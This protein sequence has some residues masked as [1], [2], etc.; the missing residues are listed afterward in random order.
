MEVT[1]CIESELACAAVPSHRGGTPLFGGS[2]HQK[3]KAI[4]LTLGRVRLVAWVATCL[5]LALPAAAGESDP[6]RSRQWNL[7]LVGS[8]QAHA[9]STG[10]GA[11]VAVIDSGVLATHPDLA[12]RLLPAMSF[13]EDG[14]TRD[15]NGHGTH[16]AG[17]VAAGAGNGVGISSIAPGATVLPIRVLDAN[18]GG[19][20]G[21]IARGIDYAIEQRADVINLSLGEEVPLAAVGARPAPEIDNAIRR[22]LDAGIVVV[23]AAGNNALPLCDQPLAERG[24]LCVGAVDK[25]AMRGSY[26]SFGS[27]VGVMAPGGSG[28]PVEG[29]NVLST[30]GDGGYEEVAGTSPATAHV[31]AVAA[32]LVSLG[33]RGEEAARRIVATARDAGGAGVDPV[34]G[35]GILDARA[36]VSGLARPGVRGRASVRRNQRIRTV[37]RRGITVRCRPALSGRCSVKARARHRTI[38]R[39]SAFATAG[40]WTIVRARVTRA[41][42]RILRRIRRLDVRVRIA[43]PGD[44]VE[45]RR[46]TLRR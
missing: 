34:Y 8:D 22:A 29:E 1:A 3:G 24:L 35:A 11:V 42:R 21:D 46:V 19:Y 6:L 4:P 9:T 10:S 5:A 12:G 30:W 17:I 16:I 45:I 37:L 43:L 18:L 2:H 31:S 41:G 26:S 40:R 36:A 44:V 15:G 28:L 13:I 39:G 25:R 33:L 32:L 7:D 14:D 27:G 23:A 38:A 20:T